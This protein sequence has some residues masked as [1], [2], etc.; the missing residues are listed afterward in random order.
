V[1]SFALLV[2]AA[3]ST[4]APPAAAD[5]A[6]SGANVSPAAADPGDAWND[7]ALRRA[8]ALWW[9]GSPDLAVERL[10]ER[11]PG[12]PETDPARADFL[13]AYGRRLRG[14][15]T[16]YL[17]AARALVARDDVPGWVLSLETLRLLDADPAGVAAGDLLRAGGLRKDGD[18]KGAL[19]ARAAERAETT[20][21]GARDE[22]RR[23]GAAALAEGRWADAG[24]ILSGVESDWMKDG[25]ELDRLAA[26]AGRGDVDELWAAWT[27]L[28]DGPGTL[29]IDRRRA[30]DE[31]A[32]L[33]AQALDGTKEPRADLVTLTG[34]DFGRAPAV[35]GLPAA[36][37]PPGAEDR[38]A[39]GQAAGALAEAR[40]DA[41]AAL[42][43]L[44]AERAAAAR[45]AAYLDL[46][47]ARAGV[48]RGAA[49]SVAARADALLARAAEI[50][51]R[52]GAARDEETR[53]IAKRTAAFAE[54]ARSNLL[55]VEA[56]RR[57]HVQGAMRPERLPEGIPTPA[58]LLEEEAK[59]VADLE[60]WFDA[61][62]TLAPEL[63]A[64][65]HDEIWVPRATGGPDELARIA[66]ARSTRAS[67][68]G[69][70]I[71]AGRA[72]ATDAAR[73][74]ALEADV[75]AEG[76]RAADAERAWRDRRR[77]TAG[78][79]IAAAQ[80]RH[81][82]E[83]EG[84]A[85]ALAVAVHESGSEDLRREAVGRYQAFLTA[86][87]VSPARSEVR[88]RLADALLQ[89][90]RDDFRGNVE[91]FLGAEPGPDDWSRPELAPFVDYAPALEQYL[92]ILEEDPA[93]AHRDAALF[94]AGM[95]L[96]DER[97]AR[98]TALLEQLVATY[99][100]SGH[101]PEAHLR[102]GDQLFDEG[103][104][105]ACLPHFEAAARGGDPE[106]AAIAL[107][108]IGWARFG[109]DRFD[110]SARAYL[111]LLDHYDAHPDAARTTDLR[112]EAEDHLVQ[113]LARGGGAEAFAR[114]FAGGAEGGAAPGDGGA[115]DGTPGG[116]GFERQTLESLGHLLRSF[117]LFDDA[118]ACDSLWMTR[119]PQ[120]AGALA[121]A[122]RLVETRE[123]AGDGAPALAARLELAPRFRRDSAWGRA[124]GD[125]LRAEGETFAREGYRTVALHHHHA[126]RG[127]GSRADWERARS[128]YGELLDG[129][130]DH[131]DAPTYHYYSGEAADALSDHTAAAA[132]F[133]A[134]ARAEG[135]PFAVDAAW[136][137]I[138][139]RDAGYESTRP[140]G[141]A[142]VALATPLGDPER[143]RDLL[144]SIDSFAERHPADERTADLLWRRGNL[145]YEHG[146]K[147]EAAGALDRFAAAYPADERA[148][149][150]ARL[151]ARALY[152]L[153]RF[154]DAG[155]A[156]AGALALARSAGADS[157]AAE[158]E[159]LLPHCRFRHAEQ[160][161]AGHGSTGRRQAAQVFEEIAG[162]WP[163]WETA[164]AALYRAG[165]AWA[166]SGERSDA[167]RAWSALTE[168]F[169][170][171]EYA[172]D[173]LLEIARTWE[174][175]DRPVAAA[176]AYR[177][178]AETFPEDPDAGAAILTS[179]DLLEAGGD[180]GRADAARDAY[181]ERYPGD[182]QTAFAVLEPRA[183]REL[184]SVGADRPVSGL[185]GVG[186]GGKPASSLGRYLE[187]AAEHDSLASPALLARV[188]FERGEEAR[189][190]YDGVRL[191][192]PLEPSIAKK[193]ALLEGALEE[194][195]AAS[196]YGVV[197]WN[198]AAAY[199][200]GECLVG[201]GD[202]LMESERP[203]D[204]SG[205]DLLAYE[206]V[207]EERSWDF[208][209]RGEETWTGLVRGA[210][211]A[212]EEW[213][214]RARSALWPRVAQRFL[215][216]PEVEH[217]VI[218]AQPP[219]EDSAQ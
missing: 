63:I 13:S 44:D 51:A 7:L 192:Q 171:S 39:V 102:L 162:R 72:G 203:A 55:V 172:R 62:A 43:R 94:H 114:I 164:D 212:D 137:A 173:A 202:A 4:A 196:A 91:R 195:R 174:G 181:L 45:D 179:A 170:E 14:E 207:L 167:V 155:V 60:S 50:T 147:D 151:R 157:V 95:I 139:A 48:E 127:N 211:A 97:D 217:P 178:F 180:P 59:L 149:P 65:S 145:A 109:L 33:V 200:I 143:A 88:F 140:A 58:Q 111:T 122:G 189:R 191:A 101:A 113:S 24:G 116:P 135:A 18:I 105:S 100:E 61:F 110:E 136:H 92:A 17:D 215:H 142:A 15:R 81:S 96:T 25:A 90:A 176:E 3:V 194:Y 82:R 210:A 138:A 104:W 57:F 199:R 118:A 10:A 152:E 37:L 40:A 28:G 41:A 71:A 9:T 126:A 64:R 36:L 166:E 12:A 154:D 112:D 119:W 125:S 206:E 76:A 141:G 120:D 129:W 11:D 23:L 182:V 86:F 130:P 133:D 117:S 198:Q 107:Y 30:E 16:A 77:E 93:W 5:P 32:A 42:R 74:A 103:E 188:R 89:V 27:A 47:L 106:H 153:E 85:Y 70:L 124:Q 83:G 56:M 1:T 123:R 165:H 80:A 87:P 115:R 99:P 156:Y 148:L 31:M 69:A 209:D 205:D 73:F 46:G 78:R 219:R 169:P 6:V 84:I 144:R 22:Q 187:L 161:I 184:Q 35:T 150:A 146:W 54:A 108:K 131:A 183:E 208:R 66:R 214:D 79:A 75:A 38:R 98:G 218:H 26:D 34:A 185:L 190:D 53:R 2:A 52:L 121:A 163:E 134:A 128:L 216:R 175:G 193:K 19:E 197:P 204:L 68:L 201:F 49:D 177:R 168:R 29:R 213:L 20:A 132:H 67:D 186:A 158:L 8:V 160:L 21:P 159:P